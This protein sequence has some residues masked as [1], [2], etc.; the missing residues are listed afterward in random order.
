M[1]TTSTS[2]FSARTQAIGLAISLAITFFAAWLGNVATMS[3]LNDWYP[4]VAKP[5]WTPPDWV[6]GPVWSALYLMMACA[7][8]LVWR[9]GGWRAAQW[10]LTLYTLQL[11]LNVLWSV[12]FFGMQQP[13]WAA[14]EIIA[15]WLAIAAT[16]DAFWRR[17]TVAG[18]LMTPYLAWVTFAAALN[19]AIARL[20]V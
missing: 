10:P 1:T 15:L 2:P 16:L 5:V 13:T 9:P 18:L 3:S 11:A 6:F 19:F 17:S 7:A 14:I 8:W 12:L 20:N 4:T